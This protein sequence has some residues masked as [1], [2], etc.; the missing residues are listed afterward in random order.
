MIVT[1]IFLVLFILSSYNKESKQIDNWNER[2]AENKSETKVISL[3]NEMNSEMQIKV[4]DTITNWQFYKDTE[5]LFKSN[6]L[7]SNRFTAKIKA[8]EKYENLILNIFYDFNNEVMKRKIELVCENKIVAT[9]FN[10]NRS[11]LSFKLPKAEIDKITNV[12]VG[13]DIYINYFDEINKNG[14]TIGILKLT[15]E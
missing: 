9:F 4:S 2:I 5:L 6:M 13:K 15:N 10:E 3:K 12:N 11:R 14:M 7:D 8:S 1:Y